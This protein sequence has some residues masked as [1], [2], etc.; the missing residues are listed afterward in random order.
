MCICV[1][2]FVDICGS[3]GTTR[4]ITIRI[5]N[6]DGCWGHAV[7]GAHTLFPRTLFQ[8]FGGGATREMNISVPDSDEGLGH[9]VAYFPVGFHQFSWIPIGF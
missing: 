6:S 3:G 4:E 7:H 1:Y 9:A 5:Q 2:V 8:W